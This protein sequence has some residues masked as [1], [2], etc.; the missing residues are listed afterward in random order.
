VSSGPLVK[1]LVEGIRELIGE[2]VQ[3]RFNK[4]LSTRLVGYGEVQEYIAI[5][6]F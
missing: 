6:A 1:C 3:I 2:R 4:S 5:S